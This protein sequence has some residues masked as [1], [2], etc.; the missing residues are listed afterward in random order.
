MGDDTWRKREEL[1][2]KRIISVIPCD[3]FSDNPLLVA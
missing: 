3:I 1:L 2:R